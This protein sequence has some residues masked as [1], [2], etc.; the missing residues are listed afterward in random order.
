MD[1]SFAI[2]K[3]PLAMLVVAMSE[4]ELFITIL[5]SPNETSPPDNN[6]LSISP[7]QAIRCSIAPFGLLPDPFRAINGDTNRPMG[8]SRG[9][10]GNL[11][12]RNQR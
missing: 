2:N 9:D 3:G 10:D 1:S 7:C 11:K 5:I 4:L 6:D 12:L 8:N